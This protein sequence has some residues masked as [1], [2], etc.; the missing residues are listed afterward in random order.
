MARACFRERRLIVGSIAILCVAD[1]M[2]DFIE[3]TAITD[4][5]CVGLRYA[6]RHPAHPPPGAGGRL[7]P[8]A[9]HPA[10]AAERRLAIMHDAGYISSPRGLGARRAR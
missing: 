9:Y 2:I 8:P 4:V 10:L 5:S 6:C 3:A 7:Y 1:G